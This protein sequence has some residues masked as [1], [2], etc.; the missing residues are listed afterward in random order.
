MRQTEKEKILKKSDKRLNQCLKADEHNR[1]EAIEDLRFLFGEQWDSGDLELRS[2]QNRQTLTVNQL[3]KYLKQAEGEFRQNK[4]SVKVRPMSSD[5]TSQIALIREGIVRKIFYDSNAETIFDQAAKM[6]LSCGFGACRVLT[7]YKNENSFNQEIYLQLLKNPLSVYIDPNCKNINKSDA[8]FAF[9]FDVM[10]RDEF[11]EEYPDI[12]I[13]TDDIEKKSGNENNKFYLDNKIV[14]AEYYERKKITTTIVLLSDD[15]VLEKKA[16]QE[17]I[18][19]RD[20]E[21]KLITLQNESLPEDNQP[22]NIPEEL[23]IIKER[24]KEDYKIYYYKR[25]GSEI[26]EGPIEVAGKYIPVVMFLGEEFNISGKDYIQGLIRNAKDPQRFLNWWISLT[27]EVIALAPKAP[28]LVTNE[29]IKGH[30]NSWATANRENTSVLIYNPDPDAPG[31]PQRNTAASIS[32]SGMFAEIQ[33]SEQFIKDAI[34]MGD[35]GFGAI[36]QERGVKAVLARH[37]NADKV[38]SIYI[39]NHARAV[40]HIGRIINNMIPIIY[41]TEMDAQIKTH[42]NLDKFAPIN[43]SVSAV[44][45]KINNNPS[46]YGGIDTQALVN[47]FA[48]EGGGS[49]V[50]DISQGEYMVTVETGPTSQTQRM[51]NAENLIRM[52]QFMP[53]TGQ[54]IADLVAKNFDFEDAPEISRRLKKLLPKGLVTLTPEDGPPLPPPPPPPQMQLEMQKAQMEVQE[55][56]VKI[57]T[58]MEKLSIDRKKLEVQQTKLMVEVAKL[59][60]EANESKGE[61]A[62]EVINV[63]SQLQK[64][65]QSTQI[66]N[67]IPMQEGQPQQGWQPSQPPIQGG[68]I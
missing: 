31:P 2:K 67:Q 48:K 49:K 65:N 50:N 53:E 26:L 38:V 44:A 27:T 9:I 36:G 17:E 39:D 8:E 28:Y 14:I 34:G 61:I 35:A 5:A 54:V 22:I 13:P 58:D 3:P 10:D 47:Q 51:E 1:K 46:I 59:K 7:R 11:E 64:V 32:P 21:I 68:Q 56:Q 60:K 23:T 19:D 45:K 20:R 62:K 42:D 57:K 16:A 15:R 25:T 6:Q 37:V 40:E 18:E 33:K 52:I 41:D 12:N 55:L 66:N 29:Q 4:C 43:T 24:E 30:E 63:L